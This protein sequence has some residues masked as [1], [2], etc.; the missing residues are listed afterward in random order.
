MEILRQS[1]PFASLTE[2]GLMFASYSKTPEIFNMMLKS[3]IKGDQDGNTDHL[4]KYTRATTA[5]AFFIPA[6]NWLTSLSN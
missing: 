5:Q 1:I 2:K 6:N 4:M 3:M